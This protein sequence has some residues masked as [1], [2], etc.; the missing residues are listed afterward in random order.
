MLK[1]KVSSSFYMN[2]VG[3]ILEIPNA[4]NRSIS[5]GRIKWTMDVIE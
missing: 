2:H 3:F 1:V 4:A 5:I